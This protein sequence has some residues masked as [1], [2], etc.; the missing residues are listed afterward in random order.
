MCIHE[1]GMWE[2]IGA[3]EPVEHISEKE[4]CALLGIETRSKTG[5]L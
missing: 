1:Y 3:V 4:F 5:K 2:D